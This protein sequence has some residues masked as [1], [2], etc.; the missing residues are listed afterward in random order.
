EGLGTR[1]WGLG[2][3]CG[4]GACAVC[5]LLT[6]RPHALAPSPFTISRG[7]VSHATCDRRPVAAPAASA[8]AANAAG[9]RAPSVIACTATAAA[10]PAMSLSGRTAVNQYSGAVIAT[11]VGSSHAVHGIRPAP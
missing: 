1:G 2:A 11:T 4:L 3:R 8:A 6:A 7:T 5:V 10:R 9:V